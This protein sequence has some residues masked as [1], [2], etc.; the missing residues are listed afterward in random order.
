MGNEE[1]A[2]ILRMV[3]EG[4]VSP[5]EGEDL[6]AALEPA[7]RAESRPTSPMPPMPPAPPL[8]PTIRTGRRR[9]L[10]IHISEGGN[11]KVNVRIPL[12]L[13]RAASKFIPRQAQ[14]YLNEREI[15]LEELLEGLGGADN[16]GTM[17]AIDDG[18]D[19]VRIAVE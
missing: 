1:R 19:K 5:A 2:R 3:A 6:L 7:P 4:K 8:P 10:V 17:I 18:E 12:G 16:D 11:S 15:N 9:T 14:A 13:A